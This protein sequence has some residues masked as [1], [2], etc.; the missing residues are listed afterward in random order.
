[1]VSSTLVSI[2][3]GAGDRPNS[4]STSAQQ[5]NRRRGRDSRE[6]RERRGMNLKWILVLRQQVGHFSLFHVYLYVVWPSYPC[7][8]WWLT[9]GLRICALTIDPP[10]IPNLFDASDNDE[11]TCRTT[12]PTWG[13]GASATASSSSS[14]HRPAPAW[15]RRSDDQFSSGTTWP[16]TWPIVLHCK[17][18]FFEKCTAVSLPHPKGGRPVY[19]CKLN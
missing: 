4:T 5:A 17:F 3:P 7:T 11:G 8:H 16:L 19:T 15:G 1:M 2:L 14:T 13:W 6:K 10:W 9:V 18:F 12:V